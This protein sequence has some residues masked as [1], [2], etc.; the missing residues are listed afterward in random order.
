M[1]TSDAAPPSGGL[2]DADSRRLLTL[3]AHLMRWS[4]RLRVQVLH[5]SVDPAEERAYTMHKAAA[6]DQLSLLSPG[7]ARH[8]EHAQEAAAE[9]WRLDSQDAAGPYPADPRAY[10]RRQYGAWLGE[11]NRDDDPLS[12]GDAWGV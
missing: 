7:Y 12:P 4:T 6:T 5:H 2:Y 8:A 3:M 10:V 9:L 1:L 11:R